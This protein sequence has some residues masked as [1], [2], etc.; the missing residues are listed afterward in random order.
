M[1]A[2]IKDKLGAKVKL[3][4]SGGG[5]FEISVDDKLIFSKLKEGRFPEE[6]EILNL[7]K[8]LEG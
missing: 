7:I 6:K 1:A 2:F 3:I 4:Q 8:D 5:A